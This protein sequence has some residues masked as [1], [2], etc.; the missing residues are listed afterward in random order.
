MSDVTPDP[1]TVRRFEELDA[2]TLYRLLRLR[3]AVFVVEQRCPYQELDDL[4]TDSG[5]VHLWVER[6][7]DIAGYLR[8]LSE[9]DGFRVGR[10]C[11]AQQARGH[12]VAR[13]LMSRAMEL[14]GEAPAVLD[15]QT[16]AQE[17]Y[18]RFGF[19]P[20]GAEFLEDD[21]PHIRMRRA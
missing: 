9:P 19:E 18:G 2:A 8:V 1:V 21:I 11:T 14:I 3:V 4:D 10:V 5:T 12:G 17:F 13:R 20:E 16:Y 7:G 6:D 15:S